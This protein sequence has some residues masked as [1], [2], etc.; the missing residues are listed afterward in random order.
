ML[1]DIYDPSIILH[2]QLVAKRGVT[3]VWG[4]VERHEKE[5]IRNFIVII[6]RFR[7][8]YRAE[9]DYNYKNKNNS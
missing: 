5:L 9:K 6:R 8:C 3:F 7:N 1:P 2:R 4:S